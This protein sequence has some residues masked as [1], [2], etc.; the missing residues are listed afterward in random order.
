MT[1]ETDSRQGQGAVDPDLRARQAVRDRCRGR[2]RVGRKASDVVLV[3]VTKFADPT[4]IRDLIAMGP[5]TSARTASRTSSAR[6]MAEEFLSRARTPRRRRRERQQRAAAS[7]VSRWHMIGT[8][9]RNKVK[10]AI[11]LSR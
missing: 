6:A 11:E 9:Q 4:Q 8:L 5:A 3:A 10:K 7:E 2:R 1:T